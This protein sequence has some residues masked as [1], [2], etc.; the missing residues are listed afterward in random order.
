MRTEKEIGLIIRELRG[1]LSLRDF[2]K[3]CEISHT[4][5]DNLEKG[6][7]HRTG[8]PTQV[9]VAT[10]QKIADACLV[11]LS[12]ITDEEKPAEDDGLSPNRRK[13]ID[14]ARSVPEDK[15]DQVYSVIQSILEAL[16]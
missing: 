8:K 9:K 15:V 12:Y 4:T 7:D 13:L 3:K 1:D 5:I 11:P 14:F 16:K 6:I 2:A 10:L